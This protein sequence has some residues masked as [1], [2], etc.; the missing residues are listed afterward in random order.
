MSAAVSG[1][2]SVQFHAWDP[3]SCMHIPVGEPV[4]TDVSDLETKKIPMFRRDKRFLKG[5]VAWDW[6]IRAASLPGN[7]LIVG[8]CLWRLRGATGNDSVRLGNGE[9]E[10]FGIDRAAKSRA[11]KVLERAQ[12]ITVDRSDSRRLMITLLS[13]KL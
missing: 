1:K 9:T 4:S 12:L 7:A 10:P 2:V 5:P 11:L 13:A 6:I 8:L 3:I